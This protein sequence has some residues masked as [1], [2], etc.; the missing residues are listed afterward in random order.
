[1]CEYLL[2]RQLADF[3]DS[4]ACAETLAYLFVS[5]LAEI[6]AVGGHCLLEDSYGVGSIAG[7]P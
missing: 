2:T 1:M 7:V 4:A 6:Q 3:A 5:C